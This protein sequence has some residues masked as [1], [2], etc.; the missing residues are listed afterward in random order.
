MSAAKYRV[1]SPEPTYSGV[2]GKC[3]FANGVYE[4]PVED[5]PL[6]YFEQAGYA[7][8]ALNDSAVDDLSEIVLG[9][10]DPDDLKG[11]ALDDALRAAGLPVTGKAGEKRA[12][13]ADYQASLKADDDNTED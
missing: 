2:T 13:L 3:Q 10:A 9:E 4:G 8:E 11:K 1:R 5:G 7:V 6:M 12:A